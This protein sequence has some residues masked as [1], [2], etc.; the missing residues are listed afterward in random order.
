MKDK[1]MTSKREDILKAVKKAGKPIC[2][3]D[4]YLELIGDKVKV[5]MSTIYRGLEFLIAKGLVRKLY[6]G[7]DSK[8]F[9]E[10]KREEHQHYLRCLG[11]NE[12]LPLCDCPVEAYEKTLSE[13][14]HYVVLGHKLEIV[15]YCSNCSNK[16]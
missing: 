16:L 1:K 14:T 7:D 12:I 10:E 8:H 2:A 5:N 6:L 3:E 15:G 13:K 11:C 9:F 4:I